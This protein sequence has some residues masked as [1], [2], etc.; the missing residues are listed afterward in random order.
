MKKPVSITLLFDFPALLMPFG[1]LDIGSG[2][3][4]FDQKATIAEFEQWLA[5]EGNAHLSDLVENAKKSKGLSVYFSGHFLWLLEETNKK[6]LA[7]IKSVVKSGALEIVGGLY[8]SSLSSIYSETQ[9]KRQVQKHRAVLKSVFG[10]LPTRFY[11]AENIY[12]QRLD[13]LIAEEGYESI[14]AGTVTWYLSNNPDQRIFKGN[15]GVNVLLLDDHQSPSVFGSNDIASCFLQFDHSLLTTYSGL[16]TIVRNLD[17]LAA[18]VPISDQ[19]QAN[20]STAAYPIKNPVSGSI[21]GLAL[22]AFTGNV[23]QNQLLRQYYQLEKKLSTTGNESLLES[24]DMLGHHEFIRQM[25]A[26][27]SQS[28]RTNPHDLYVRFS[29]ILSDL[30]IRL[31][32]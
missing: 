21:H 2:K 28:P 18:L 3:E 17:S 6:A 5:Q 8:H 23:L 32:N 12:F 1:F 30:E 16:G 26:T 27:A 15:N 11:N 10:V 4:Y 24:W 25:G 22:D 14:F 19:L 31:V 7:D 20:S 29:S 9:F 13:D